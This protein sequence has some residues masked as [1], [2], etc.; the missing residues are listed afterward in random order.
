M[1]PGRGLRWLV[2]SGYLLAIYATLGVARYPVTWLRARGLLAAA[3]ALLFLGAGTAVIAVGRL[4]GLSASQLAGQAA[5]L[6]AYPLLARWASTPEE[7]I[8]FV[9]Y[10]LVGILLA[11]AL[12]DPR[13]SRRLT[14]LRALALGSVAGVVDEVLQGFIPGRV[15]DWRD[16]GI[17]CLAVALGLL[18]WLPE[19]RDTPPAA[20]P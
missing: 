1:E 8:H 15:F 12:A 9:Q 13:N 16:I 11:W 3:V 7:R 2:V 18:H 4:R 5:L 14:A 6:F 17:N 10:G 20:P 19:G